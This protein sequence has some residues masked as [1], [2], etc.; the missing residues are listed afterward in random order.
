MGVQREVPIKEERSDIQQKPCATTKL[1][2]QQQEVVDGSCR[3][4]L[5]TTQVWIAISTYVLLANVK[6]ELKMDR[7]QSAYL[8]F[9]KE[10][11]SP[12]VQRE[13]SS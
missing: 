7:S 4:R 1:A 8:L 9:V 10:S 3:L 2:L 5:S 12:C 6:R 13:D 11:Q